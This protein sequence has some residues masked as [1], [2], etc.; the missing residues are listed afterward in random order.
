MSAAN[1]ASENF[2][3]WHNQGESDSGA[4]RGRNWELPMMPLDWA[5]QAIRVVGTNSSD[6]I[7]IE[8][9]EYRLAAAPRI[10]HDPTDRARPMR[11]HPQDVRSGLVIVWLQPERRRAI[12]SNRISLC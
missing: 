11:L 8:N 6:K 9:G 4:L 5:A 2:F 1:F 10:K 7:E 12:G 3:F